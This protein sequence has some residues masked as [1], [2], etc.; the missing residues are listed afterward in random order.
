MTR[1]TV[2]DEKD[3]AKG[4]NLSKG[5]SLDVQLELSFLVALLGNGGAIGSG[6]EKAMTSR[7]SASLP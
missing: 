5:F 2:M 3:I 7:S 1:I 4:T 6:F